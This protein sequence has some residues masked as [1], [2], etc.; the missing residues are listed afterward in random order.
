MTDKPDP[1]V[2]AASDTAL[3]DAIAEYDRLAAIQ[4]GLERRAGVFRP[5]IPE[6]EEATRAQEAAWDEVLAA[7]KAVQSIPATTQV[8]LFAR[9]QATDR[10]MTHLQEDDLYDEDWRIIKADVQRIAGE[11]ES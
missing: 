6:A 10:F 2:P 3:F 5:G 7:W 9:L 4:Q 8:G 11:A 1:Q